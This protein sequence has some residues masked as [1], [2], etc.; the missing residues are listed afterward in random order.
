MQEVTEGN[1][2]C[3]IFHASIETSGNSHV[4]ARSRIA[5][6]HRARWLWFSRKIFKLERSSI[7]PRRTTTNIHP[8]GKSLQTAPSPGGLGASLVSVILGVGS[9]LGI[10]DRFH[11]TVAYMGQLQSDRIV[12]GRLL[13]GAQL[14]GC[15]SHMGAWYTVLG[16][17]FFP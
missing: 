5:E 12:S 6:N 14:G 2:R 3:Y 10:R 4:G 7:L 1:S 13:V 8:I 15:W 9:L 17:T 11:F 16:R